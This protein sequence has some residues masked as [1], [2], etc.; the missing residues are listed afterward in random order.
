[1][2][3]EEFCSRCGIWLRAEER[4]TNCFVCSSPPLP[5]SAC[6]EV[7]EKYLYGGLPEVDE[8]ELDV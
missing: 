2:S 5:R 1:M 7:L 4:V 3:E 8:S 6:R